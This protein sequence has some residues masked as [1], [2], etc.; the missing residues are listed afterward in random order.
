MLIIMPSTPK[1]VPIDEAPSWT[2]DNRYIYHGYRHNHKSLGTILRSFFSAH[3]ELLNIWTHLIGAIVFIVFLVFLFSHS[4]QTTAIYQDYKQKFVTSEFMKSVYSHS[5]HISDYF[6]N[7]HLKADLS[8]INSKLA[9]LKADYTRR[10]QEFKDQIIE[11]ETA[12]VKN[13]NQKFE[14]ARRKVEEVLNDWREQ[15]HEFA[16]NADGKLDGLTDKID[17]VTNIDSLMHFLDTIFAAEIEFY[18]VVVYTLCAIACLGLSATFHGFFV[19]NPRVCKILQKCDYAGIVILIFGSSYA[20]FFYEFYCASFWRNAYLI[21]IGVASVASF[22][23]SLSEYVDREEGKAFLGLM[24]GALGVSNIF[25]GIHAIFR[26]LDPNTSKEMLDITNF[27]G[28]VRTG[29]FYLG[30]LAVYISRFPE[31][32][33]PKRFDIWFNSHSIWH[34]FVFLGALS[35]YFTVLNMYDGRLELGCPA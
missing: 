23:T 29:A 15:L 35:H 13:L 20:F 31:K 16:L 8:A 11:K 27:V 25:P 10:Y 1:V 30:G 6:S 33:Y 34:V 28:F 3:N 9:E 4:A 32:Y 24:M 12:L 2:V 7:I 26:S 17:R 5:Q 19:M 14:L 21:F 18:P 22:V